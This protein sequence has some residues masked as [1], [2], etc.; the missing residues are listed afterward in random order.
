MK[1]PET[2]LEISYGSPDI[3]SVTEMLNGPQRSAD[4]LNPESLLEE[5]DIHLKLEVTTSAQSNEETTPA[6]DIEENSVGT[7]R[8][9]TDQILAKDNLNGPDLKTES[10]DEINSGYDAP[11]LESNSVPST[12]YKSPERKPELR[13]QDLLGQQP[14][15]FYV[16]PKSMKMEN[17]FI[18]PEVV[19]RINPA[20]ASRGRKLNQKNSK[21]ANSYGSP[22]LFPEP[23]VVDIKLDISN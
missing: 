16:T 20:S 10:A 14:L 17:T 3:E 12:L 1:L 4:D 22:N 6:L 7:N 18:K 11:Q 15:P 21:P 19:K 9:I 2:N 5:Q 23:E 13:S 8:T